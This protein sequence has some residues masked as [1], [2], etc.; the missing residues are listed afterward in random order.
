MTSTNGIL[1]IAVLIGL[2]PATIA[3]HKGRPFWKWWIYGAALFIVALIH[4]LL[5]PTPEDI[6]RADK[7]R[8]GYSACPWC[9]EMVRNEALIC[10]YCSRDLEAV[11]R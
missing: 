7:A 10:R 1:I 9:A 5:I 4:A 3:E 8:E 2:I 6:K 11:R